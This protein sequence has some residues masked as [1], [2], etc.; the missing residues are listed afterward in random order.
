M[1]PITLTGR[2]LPP[3]V[4]RIC[5]RRATKPELLCACHVCTECHAAF[6]GKLECVKAKKHDTSATKKY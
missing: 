2:Y 5:E 6:W 1:E 4:C 3:D